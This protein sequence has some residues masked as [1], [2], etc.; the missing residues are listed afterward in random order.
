MHHLI[1]HAFDLAAD[2]D[3]LR[4]RPYGVIEVCGGRLAAIHLRPWPKFVSLLDVFF[5]NWYHDH[6]PGDHVRLFYNQPRRFPNFLTLKYVISARGTSWATFHRA[7]ATLDEIARLKRSDALLCDAANFR[8][9]PRLMAREGWQ[10]HTNSRWHRNY[11]K[12]FYGEY[13][14]L[15]VE[16]EADRTLAMTA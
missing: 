1:E 3:V 15:H 4:R 5:G 13:P 14:R 12:R 2:A 7:L 6:M 10:A 8:I 16:S 9:S 11:I